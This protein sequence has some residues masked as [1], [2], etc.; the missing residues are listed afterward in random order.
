MQVHAKKRFQRVYINGQQL[1]KVSEEALDQFT[2]Y[3]IQ[4]YVDSMQSSYLMESK[5][6]KEALDKLLNSKAIY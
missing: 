5:K 3:E 2:K 4:A 6:W 1:M